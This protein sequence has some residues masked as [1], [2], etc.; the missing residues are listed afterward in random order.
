MENQPMKSVEFEI[1][2][3]IAILHLDGDINSCGIVNFESILEEIMGRN[4]LTIAVDCS[5]LLV[6]D[7]A[8]VS[9]LAKY[10]KKA[11]SN[12]IELV[13]FNINPEVLMTITL[14]QADALF[15]LVTGEQFERRYMNKELLN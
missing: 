14:M 13:L 3:D 12:N 9:Q 4:P 5:N 1:I 6:L 8:T 11:R 10:L 15:T 2:E 7:S